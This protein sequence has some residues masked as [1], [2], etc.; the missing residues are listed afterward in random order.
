MIAL[1]LFGLPLAVFWLL[2]TGR[3]DAKRAAQRQDQQMRQLMVTMNP[4]AFSAATRERVAREIRREEAQARLPL[5]LFLLLLFAA[6]AGI[7]SLFGH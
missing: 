6:L 2:L 5:G 1:V 4:A 7:S 3:D